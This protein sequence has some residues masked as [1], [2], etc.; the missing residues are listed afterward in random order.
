MVIAE[1]IPESVKDADPDTVLENVHN[2]V[3]R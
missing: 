1:G 2:A 3:S